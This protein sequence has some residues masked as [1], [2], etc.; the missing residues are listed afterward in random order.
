MDN[1]CLNGQKIFL[2]QFIPKGHP[3]T[4]RYVV[5]NEPSYSDKLRL[6]VPD[7]ANVEKLEPLNLDEDNDKFWLCCIA[8]CYS[9]P[10]YLV[11]A[12]NEEDALETFLDKTDVATISA[13]N[14]KDYP[15]DPETGEANSRIHFSDGGKMCDIESYHSQELMLV[16]M[17]TEWGHDFIQ[18]GP[19]KRTAPEPVITGQRVIEPN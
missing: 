8:D 4:T 10:L 13:E 7:A 19:T 18:Q 16:M 5:C 3:D 15:D 12:Q 6:L 11:R 17:I 2:L 14:L 9:P 1:F